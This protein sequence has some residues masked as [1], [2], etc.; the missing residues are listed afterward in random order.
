MLLTIFKFRIPRKATRPGKQYPEFGPLAP[1]R[2]M[3]SF[4]Q[5]AGSL[6]LGA[7]YL[8]HIFHACTG[9][10]TCARLIACSVDM[11]EELALYTNRSAVM[12]SVRACRV[13]STSI[14]DSVPCN[15][16]TTQPR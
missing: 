5:T 12:T 13:A 9:L 7:D 4:I 16:G 8:F 2:R 1:P 3:S 15:A 14:A 6:L 10:V 11:F